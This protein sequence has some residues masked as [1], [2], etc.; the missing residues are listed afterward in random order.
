MIKKIFTFFIIFFSIFML[1]NTCFGLEYYG[2]KWG[3][4]TLSVYI[5]QNGDYSHMMLHAFQ[6]WQN[7]CYGQ[8]KFDFTDKK[9]ADIEVDFKDKTDGTDGDIGSYTMTIQGGAIS[10]VEIIIAPQNNPDNLVYTVMLHEVGHA[11]GLRDS[12]RKLGIMHSPVNAQQNIISNDIV[13][14]YRL[15]GWSYMNK[16]NLPSF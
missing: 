14:L 7:K 13:K 2:P 15:N 6:E 9:P 3:K 5:P 4:E 10:K 11:L 8:L 1:S 16:S 12:S